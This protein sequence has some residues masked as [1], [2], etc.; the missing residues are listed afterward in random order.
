MSGLTDFQAEVTR[1]FFSLP[2]SEGFLLAGGGALLAAGL[3][4]DRRRT[5]TSSVLPTV[6]T[7]ELRGISS[8]SPLSGVAGGASASRR[9]TPSSGSACL[10]TTR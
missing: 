6:S 1:L 2:A 8:R 10:A 9:A 5:S 7:S 4:S 3:P